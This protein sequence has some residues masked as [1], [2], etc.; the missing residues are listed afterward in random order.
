M[1]YQKSLGSYIFEILNVLFMLVM[2]FICVYPFYY[3]ITCSLSNS[4]L[5]MGNR[6]LMLWPKGFS[7]AAYEKVLQNPNIYTG[8]K[9]TLVV[10][11]GGTAINIVC[12]SIGA[13]LVTR[14]KFF[15]AKPMMVMMVI[16]MY[17]SGGMIPTYLLISQTLGLRDSLWAL[18]LPGAISTYNL[19]I[20]KTQ[21]LSIPASLEESAKL[22]GANDI[23]V[24]IRII[25]PLSLSTIAVMVLFYGVANWN[26]WFNALLYIDTREKYPLQL[27]LREILLLNST[28]DMMVGDKGDGRAAVAESIKYATIIVA[29]VPILLVYP[30]IQKYFVKGVMVGAVKG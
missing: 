6:G 8:Y 4:N 24:L 5:L 12:T 17:F 9:S 13:F 28:T 1:K 10:V 26:A 27:V 20:M 11:F 22:D 18:V 3:V 14:K 21:F 25:L 7:L 15:L 19:I 30:F 16:T 23:W 2:I 29:T